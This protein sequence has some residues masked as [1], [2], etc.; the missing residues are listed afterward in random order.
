[1]ESAAYRCYSKPQTVVKRTKRGRKTKER[2]GLSWG[3]QHEEGRTLVLTATVA[4]FLFALEEAHEQMADVTRG[5]SWVPTLCHHAE[6]CFSAQEHWPW[7]FSSLRSCLVLWLRLPFL[8]VPSGL[9]LFLG[10]EIIFSRGKTQRGTQAIV[11][12]S[13]WNVKK[14]FLIPQTGI[15][16]GVGDN[17]LSQH[18]SC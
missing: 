18:S 15:S 8:C 2:R 11:N 13:P 4:D 9:P 16:L 17:S 10:S 12:G 5:R 7:P 3:L 1:M 14:C 6:F